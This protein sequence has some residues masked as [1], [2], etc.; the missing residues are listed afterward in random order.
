ML[1]ILEYQV[2]GNLSIFRL[3]ENVEDE[4]ESIDQFMISLDVLFALNMIDL[5]E[6]NQTIKYVN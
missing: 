6:E 3:Y 1:P 4:F 2:Y 5:D